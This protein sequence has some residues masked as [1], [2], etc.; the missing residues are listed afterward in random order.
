MRPCD[1][2]RHSGGRARRRRR[3][4][5]PAAIARLRGLLRELA[6]VLVAFSGGVDS[7]TLL[8]VALDELGPEAVLAVTAHG[9]VHTAEELGAAREAAARMGARHLVITTNELAVPG[10]AANPPERCFLCKHALYERLLAH[11]RRRG[12]EDRGRRGQ[13]PTTR[14]TTGRACRAAAALGV[15]SPLAEAG[16]GKD[17]VRALARE[18]GLPEWDRPASPVWLRAFPTERRSQPRLCAW[19]ARRRGICRIWGSRSVG[20]ATTAAWPASRWTRNGR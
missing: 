7:G 14:A 20:C 13:P 10:F 19:W 16:L 15:R 5:D 4:A 18:L 17:E 6:P 12:P 2:P 11:R 3:A 9:D 1:T 8:K